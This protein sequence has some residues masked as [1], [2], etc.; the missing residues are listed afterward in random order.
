MCR[1][2]VIPDTNDRRRRAATPP[3]PRGYT[4]D[5]LYQRV[6][7]REDDAVSQQSCPP[8]TS[9]WDPLESATDEEGELCSVQAT[10]ADVSSVGYS[11]SDPS[12]SPT[13]LPD[14]PP[15]EPTGERNEEAANM[16]ELTP[17]PPQNG[18]YSTGAPQECM[19]PKDDRSQEGSMRAFYSPQNYSGAGQYGLPQWPQWM[20]PQP[21]YDGSQ[22]GSM[23]AFYSPH[24]N[25]GQYGHQYGQ[26]GMQQ[27]CWVYGHPQQQSQQNDSPDL[28]TSPPQAAQGPCPSA[29]DF[30]EGKGLRVKVRVVERNGGYRDA[31][32]WSTEKRS[33]GEDV[34]VEGD[35]D[36]GV[37][38]IVEGRVLHF[39]RKPVRW[40]KGNKHLRRV[41]G[42]ASQ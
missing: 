13:R 21:I 30:G 25:N 18:G 14:V 11:Y 23:Y 37:Q 29:K 9:W 1:F 17:P 31:Y 22:E 24:N 38:H 5:E 8:C 33:E 40:A 19:Q 20:Q 2:G 32:Y 39:T 12:S 42:K 28:P 6:E 15:L 41:I 35:L 27:G 34:L 7:M 3:P 10:D 16:T 4:Q 26:F 36:R